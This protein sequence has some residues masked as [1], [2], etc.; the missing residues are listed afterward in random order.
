[1][2]SILF[3]TSFLFI[4]FTFSQGL[5]L[6]PKAYQSV[7]QFEPTPKGTLKTIDDKSK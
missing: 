5:K 6:D 7:K 2:K 1:M 3:G 4:G